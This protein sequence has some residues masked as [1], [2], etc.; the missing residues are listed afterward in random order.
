MVELEVKVDS[1][2]HAIIKTVRYFVY[3]VLGN[4]QQVAPCTLLKLKEYEGQKFSGESFHSSSTGTPVMDN[5]PAYVEWGLLSTVKAGE[6]SIFLGDFVDIGVNREPERRA[7][8]E[9]LLPKDPWYEIRLW[10]L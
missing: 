4:N 5:T 8:E 1:Q 7:D 2:I 9:T 10:L 3:N 6:Y